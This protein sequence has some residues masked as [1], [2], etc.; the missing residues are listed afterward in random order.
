M[1][2]QATRD[3]TF[4]L[5]CFLRHEPGHDKLCAVTPPR[6]DPRCGVRPLLPPRHPRRGH[7]RSGRAGR[8]GKGHLYRHFPSKDELVLAFLAVAR[9]VGRRASSRQARGRGATRK[10]ACSPSS[11][12]STTGSRAQSST[13]APSS[14]CCSRWAPSMRSAARASAT[15]RTSARSSSELAEEAGLRDTDSFARSWHILMKGSIIS[16]AEGDL[17]AAKRAQAMAKLLIEQHRG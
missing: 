8:R 17:A 4:C 11:T 3:R 12:S 7:R 1:A 16:A 13:R 14:T 5:V 6:A 9:S 2:A 10:N 15:S